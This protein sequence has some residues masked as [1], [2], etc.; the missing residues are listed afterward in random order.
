MCVEWWTLWRRVAGG[1]P[2]SAQLRLMDDFALI[3]DDDKEEMRKRAVPVVKGTPDDMIRLAASLERIPAEFKYQVGVWLFELLQK[4]LERNADGETQRNLWAIARLG[5]R[6]PLYGSAHDVI[7]P[8][9][10]ADWLELLLQLDW[11]RAPH[12]AASVAHLARM[13]GDRSRD[14]DDEL[15]DQ[16]LDRLTTS[17]SAPA[18]AAMVSQV[19]KLDAAEQQRA[20]G[21]ALPPGLKLLG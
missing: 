2:A 3:L 20:L 7:P 4:S 12:T 17:R 11:K 13:T 10:I 6:Q 1:L 8:A 5:A 16:V 18:L 15:R 9:A 14:I 21:E 19:V